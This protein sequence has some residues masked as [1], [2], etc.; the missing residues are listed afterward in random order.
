MV[1]PAYQPR[2]LAAPGFAT[3]LAARSGREPTSFFPRQ[4]ST[5]PR[6]SPRRTGSWTAAGATIRSTSGSPRRTSRTSGFVA[7]S[8]T[9]ALP[10]GAVAHASVRVAARRRR[11]ERVGG[12]VRALDQRTFEQVVHGDALARH[13]R[14]PRLAD[15]GCAAR[16]RHD[17][18]GLQMLQRDDHGHQLRDAR[19]RYAGARVVR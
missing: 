14:D 8:A 19:D 10:Y 12:I 4:I 16:H 17:L 15:L 2:R 11:S 3:A 5:Q 6:A 9:R 1:R 18:R 13:E 7:T